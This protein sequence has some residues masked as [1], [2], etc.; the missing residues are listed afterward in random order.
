MYL[1]VY[2]WR[3]REAASMCASEGGGVASV[4]PRFPAATYFVIVSQ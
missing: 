1:D 2:E 4:A 3:E